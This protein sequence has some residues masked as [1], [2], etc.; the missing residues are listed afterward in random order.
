M[1][2]LKN[3]PPPPFP[4]DFL[5]L[6]GIPQV[7]TGH[8]ASPDENPHP[9][10][11]APC[12]GAASSCLPWHRHKL[13]G[14]DA[15]EP[16]AGGVPAPGQSSPLPARHGHVQARSLP[17]CA[18]RP[19]PQIPFLEFLTPHPAQALPRREGG[20][21]TPRPGGDWPG[22]SEEDARALPPGPSSPQRALCCRSRARKEPLSGRRP[23]APLP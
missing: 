15:A 6:C 8:L 13:R 20:R 14:E 1:N 22:T 9:S 4:V 18:P 3:P 12:P 19:P 7:S 5:W 2:F 10:L 17:R 23:L 11:R 21:G 16:M